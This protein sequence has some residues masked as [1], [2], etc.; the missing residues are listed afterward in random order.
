V[1]CGFAGSNFP[2][3]VF[4]SVVGRPI[5]RAEEKVEGVEIKVGFFS[6]FFLSICSYLFVRESLSL[7]FA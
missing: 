2:F 3:A 7:F 6:F 5:L 1:K 4:P